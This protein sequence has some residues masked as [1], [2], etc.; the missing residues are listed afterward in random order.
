MAL[1]FSRLT[2]PAV[3]ALGPNE[4]LIEHGIMAERLANGDVRYSVN[5][6]V[7]GERIHRVVGRESEGVTREQAERAIE[8]LRTKAREGRLDLPSARKTHLS[9]REA[10][11]LYLERLERIGGKGIKEKRR[12]LNQHLNLHF[13]RLQAGKITE[14]GVQHYTHS[15]LTERA[16][17]ATVNRELSTLSHMLRR[18]AEWKCIKADDVPKII[19]GAEPRKKIVVLTLGE[20]EALMQAAVGDQDPHTWLFVAIAL[21]TGMRHSEILRIK[22]SDIDFDQRRIYVAQAKAGQRVQPMPP[23]LANQLAMECERRSDSN[24]YIFNATRADSKF[25]YRQTMAQQFRR[26]VEQAKLD[27]TKVTPHVLRHTAIT[28]LVQAGVDLVTIQ[29]VSGH[30]TLAMVLR[31]AHLSG[32]HIDS[33]V[34]FL[35]T[36]LPNPITPKLHT[37]SGGKSRR[38]A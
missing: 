27:P 33:A 14:F 21:Q 13:G 31:Y 3:R 22:W 37:V 25:D 29:R 23:S 32:E 16:K 9:F 34:A 2:R 19:K 18:L 17:Q 36:S 15:R 6:M 28:T 5:I 30:K 11:N 38:V 1:K 12:H 8:S 7:D 35:D 20:Q 26:A 4:R 10:A 24:G